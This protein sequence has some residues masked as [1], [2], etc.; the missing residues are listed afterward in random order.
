[1]KHG[2]GRKAGKENVMLFKNFKK[3]FVDS[4][5]RMTV[6]YLDND[7][8]ESFVVDYLAATDK[9]NVINVVRLYE[10]KAKL[11]SVCYNKAESLNEITVEVK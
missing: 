11:V 10:K 6:H 2:K 9:S 4:R 5:F 3:C 7:S 8:F 1:M